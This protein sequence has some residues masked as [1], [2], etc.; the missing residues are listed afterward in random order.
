MTFIV[1]QYLM[2]FDHEY[3]EAHHGQS[4]FKTEL[5]MEQETAFFYLEKN[6]DGS[7][8]ATMHRNS[9]Q[10]SSNGQNNNRAGDG[11]PASS[12]IS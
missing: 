11:G 9:D 1:V 2:Y 8:Y 10:M 5:Y 6:P 4:C 7:S 12:F 3:E